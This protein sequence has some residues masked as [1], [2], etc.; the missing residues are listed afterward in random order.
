M[1]TQGNPGL[2]LGYEG[3]R[4][5]RI[6]LFLLSPAETKPSALAYHGTGQRHAYGWHLGEAGYLLL[7][8]GMDPDRFRLIAESVYRSMLEAAPFN[9]TTKTALARSRAETRPCLS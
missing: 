5:C 3:T 9:E 4:G 1:G 8:E 6:S 2:H 7:A